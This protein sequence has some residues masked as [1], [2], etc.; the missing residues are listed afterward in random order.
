MSIILQRVYDTG[1]ITPGHRILVDRVW[2]RGISKERAR[3]KEWRRDLAPS[4][5]LRQWFG[6]DPSRWDEFRAKY[7]AEL[8]SKQ[9]EMERLKRIARRKTLVL[10]YGAKDPGHNQAV[11]LAEILQGTK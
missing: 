8:K 10:L 2:P 11:V 6:H 7:R 1:A 4:S 9:E 3:L 5:K